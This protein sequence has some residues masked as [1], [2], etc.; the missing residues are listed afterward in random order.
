MLRDAMSS[1]V[2]D[3]P[4][5]S[6]SKRYRCRERFCRRPLV[7]ESLVKKA[8][9]SHLPRERG[10]AVQAM[11]NRRRTRRLPRD[12]RRLP[13]PGMDPD[14]ELIAEHRRLSAVVDVASLLGR[15]TAAVRW[16]VYE[17]RD[18]ETEL[19]ARGVRVPRRW[20]TPDT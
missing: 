3:G 6:D 9:R 11:N 13:H 4:I 20:F 18:L 14:A 15:E 16:T 1:P 10:P 19:D 5:D 8:G 12:F 2:C 17:L 7:K